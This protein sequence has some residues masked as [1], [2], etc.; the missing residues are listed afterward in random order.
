MGGLIREGGWKNFEELTSGGRQ[1]GLNISSRVSCSYL[2]I[3]DGTTWYLLQH[4]K[5]KLNWS[6]TRFYWLSILQ[7]LLQERESNILRGNTRGV[8]VE[9]ALQAVV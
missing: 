8:N 1:L 5:T 2:C 3:I 7:Q 4:S 6:K 9:K